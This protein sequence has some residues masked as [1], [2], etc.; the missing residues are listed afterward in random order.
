MGTD[1]T[2]SPSHRQTNKN[3]RLPIREGSGT[4]APGDRVYSLNNAPS[5]GSRL[6][7]ELLPDEGT[8][9]HLRLQ[10]TRLRAP[11]PPSTL[12]AG[13][14]K[15]YGCRG[16]SSLQLL[17]GRR[18]LAS[19]SPRDSSAARPRFRLLAVPPPIPEGQLWATS[20]QPQEACEKIVFGICPPPF[21]LG[22]RG[23]S[24]PPSCIHHPFIMYILRQDLTKLL[25][26]AENLSSSYPS[27]LR[28]WKYNPTAPGP[29]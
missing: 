2:C 15:R 17:P 28:N 19:D 11:R 25:R 8:A 6:S 16:P 4:R 23:C 26:Q 21:P 1:R 22:T 5:G 20:Y 12:R 13:S 14:A 18:A 24:R 27:F 9:T 7:P 3:T 10:R 29:T